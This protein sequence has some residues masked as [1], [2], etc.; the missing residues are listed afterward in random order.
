L[1]AT[2]RRIAPV[3]WTSR[4]STYRAVFARSFDAVRLVTRYGWVLSWTREKALGACPWRVLYLLWASL[5]IAFSDS[6]RPSGLGARLLGGSRGKAGRRWDM[7]AVL[8]RILRG[9][10]VYSVVW[11]Y[12]CTNLLDCFFKIRLK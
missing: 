2:G 4:K 8:V 5:R 3:W 6:A 12:V 10:A 9:A 11:M 7:H 1:T